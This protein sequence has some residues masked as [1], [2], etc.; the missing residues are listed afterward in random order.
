MEDPCSDGNVLYLDCTDVN[1]L[2]VIVYYNSI[3]CYHWE[4]QGKKYTRVLLL[5]LHANQ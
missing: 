2:V 4:K 5:Q 1:T 3:R